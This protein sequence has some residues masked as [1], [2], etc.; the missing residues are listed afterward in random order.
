[1]VLTLNNGRCLTFSFS[2]LIS[3]VVQSPDHT[4]LDPLTRPELILYFLFISQGLFLLGV[5][6]T[7]SKSE[8]RPTAISKLDLQKIKLFSRQDKSPFVYFFSPLS[9]SIVNIFYSCVNP[10]TL[11]SPLDQNN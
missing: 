8:F 6:D 3:Y 1:M 4:C 2:F 5:V 9:N 11:S 7:E 10:F